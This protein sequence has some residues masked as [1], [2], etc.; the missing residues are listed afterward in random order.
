M[1]FIREQFT[2]IRTEGAIL[3]A[4][5]L[6]RIAA[7]DAKLDGLSPNSYHLIEGERL[8]EATNHA[9]N[10][11]L[12]AW[13]SFRT[14][15]DKYSP[16][17]LGFNVVRDRWLMPLFQELGYGR[18]MPAAPAIIDEKPY[19]IAYLWQHTP[20]HAVGFRQ[21]LDKRV[22]TRKPEEP[23]ASPHGLLQEL[24]NRSGSFLWGF[25][26]NGLKLRILRDN[27]RLT[28]QAYVEFDLQAMFEGRVYANFALLWRLC[29]Q[30]RVEAEN[31]HDCWLEKWSK[32]AHEHGLRV[33][34]Q[35]RGGVETAISAFG[36]GFLAANQSLRDKLR[37]GQLD[38]QD[39]YR[40]LLRLVYRLL[41]LFVA[42]DRDAL[43]SPGATESAR[44][45]YRRFYSTARL[46]RMS[47]RMRGSQHVDQFEMLRLV[48]GKLA[49]T[50]CPD[51]GLPAL[52]G[53]LFSPES[54]PDLSECVLS[55]ATLLEA[56]RALAVTSDGHASRP[57]DYRNLG[58]EELGS[59][60][61]SLLEL[62]PVL[63][64]EAAT[65]ELKTE[66]G[67]ERKTSGSYYTPTSLITCLLDAAL[68]PVLD[69][70]AR[71][72]EPEV[73]ILNLKVCDPACGSGHFLVAAAHRIA[74]RLAFIR[75]G[76]EE[77][78]P[79]AVRHALRDV[80]GHCIYGVDIN[81]MAVELCKVSLWMEALEPGKPL[82]FLDHHVQCGNS[83]LGATPALL[84][85]GIP[86]EAF[87]PVEGDVKAS[88]T[89]LK[90]QN[91][92]ERQEFGSG[93]GYLFEPHLN[94]GTIAADFANLNASADDTVEDVVA[95]RDWYTA[96]VGSAQYQLGRLLGDLWCATFVWKKDTSD[97]GKLC[98]TER[99]YRNAEGNAGSA[100][101]Q[102]VI[103]E[104]E[105]LRDRF[106]FFHWHLAFPDVFQVPANLEQA[107]NQH[108][109]WT[110]GF[111]VVLGNPPW[112]RQ[113]FLKP[114]KQILQTFASFSSTA[115]SSV[116]FLERALQ[117]TRLD[118]RVGMLTPN[119]WF[120][121]DYAEALRQF[122]QDSAQIC[123]LVD[124]GHSRRLFP[125]ADTF[126]AAVVFQPTAKAA[127]PETVFHFVKAHDDDLSR[128]D[129]SSLISHR[130]MEIPHSFLTKERWQLEDPRATELLQRLLRTGS[131]LDALLPR[132][133]I[134]GILT[135]LNDAFYVSREA[136]NQLVESAR[137]SQQLLRPFLR[138][139]DIGR[140]T[141]KWADQWHILIA[142]S[143]NVKWPWSDASSED[144]AEELFADSY[145][146]IHRHLK[147]F[148]E[149]LRKRQDRGRYWWELRAC[150]YYDLFDKPK[151][152]VQCIAYYSQF[153][154]D[155]D[156]F[157]L[158]NKTIFLPTD[159]LYVL[160][161]LN[162][163]VMWWIVNRLF[164]HMKD[165]GLSVDVQFVKM[166]PLP[167]CSDAL[168]A[169]V[170]ESVGKLLAV[171]RQQNDMAIC[172]CEESLNRLI[173]QAFELT[174]SELRTLENSLPPRDP[175]VTARARVVESG[176][177]VS[178][179]PQQLP[180][181]AFP[182]TPTERLLC[183]AV[184][185]LVQATSGLSTFAYAETLN[186][187]IAPKIAEKLFHDSELKSWKAVVKKA[188]A[189]LVKRCETPHLLQYRDALTTMKA[190]ATDGD[191]ITI[192]P[193]WSEVRAILPTL[194][195]TLIAL[196]SKAAK[197][198]RD[199]ATLVGE[200]RR[201]AEAARG[202]LKAAEMMQS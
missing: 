202:E 80:I 30:S 195:A 13:T 69:Q 133:P 23:S 87:T 192:G 171:I 128:H 36:R 177:N 151:I 9:W 26:T 40:Q 109:R 10:R 34:D 79:A 158:N 41:F 57:V 183:A 97:L 134:R 14:V 45:R 75:T 132:P 1:A 160:A 28:R 31:P 61:E 24:L 131:P 139:R 172:R 194:D 111:D 99:D 51:L 63:N 92:K 104:V 90:K 191:N 83:L 155:S 81:P 193:K 25:A 78:T 82:S 5:L 72:A 150:D 157:V 8:N 179:G 95:M 167:Q 106:Q 55:N 145:P 175:V 35:L 162:S 119:K 185:D 129:L 154:L 42:E 184:L 86:D 113:E 115:D 47:E 201:K 56:I 189:E 64:V 123:L 196:V 46:R 11:L 76:E 77:P 127:T 21:D 199:Y 74:K 146:A 180:D 144:E 12:S 59:V 108:T 164:Q 137:S 32:A 19:P 149:P 65:F 52:G 174:P 156:G 152:V 29:H 48:M 186:L 103:R 198:V 33:L 124:F 4:D 27:I 117:I 112:V 39:Y 100:L 60:Y 18:L 135:G 67:H 169:E 168:R 141:C 71:Q 43:F 17:D 173:E 53:F 147:Q 140:W 121:A 88:V 166:L 50:G 181:P 7:N 165:D 200:Q 66:S 138:G 126:P 143:Q 2:S 101:P 176:Q 49:Q 120:R 37:A 3:P 107:E 182:S 187:L 105:E 161:V 170:C 136:K 22:P 93:Q 58:S 122:L 94:L 98:P 38:S 142:S 44:E 62:H 178:E 70:A 89:A 85:S 20:I 84:A 114:I 190:L 102:A 91:K 163:R 16:A 54:L 110:G 188:P 15:M 125:A 118:N 130:S 153:A 197:A 73:A 68:N 159:D 148:E 116:F 6:Q 96:L